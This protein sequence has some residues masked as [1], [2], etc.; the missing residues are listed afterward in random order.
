M[1][2]QAKNPP[3]NKSLHEAADYQGLLYQHWTFENQQN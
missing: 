2:M 3:S 1:K